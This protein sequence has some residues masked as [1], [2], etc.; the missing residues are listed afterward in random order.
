MDV[1]MGSCRGPVGPWAVGPVG[2][3]GPMAHGLI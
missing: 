3:W 2:L 1:L